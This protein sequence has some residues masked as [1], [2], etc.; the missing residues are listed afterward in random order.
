LKNSKCLLS[1][2]E[3][4][5]LDD[6]IVMSFNALCLD[7]KFAFYL[8]NESDFIEIVMSEITTCIDNLPATL[9]LQGNFNIVK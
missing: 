5:F 6:V 9:N 2:I 1:E 3:K 8:I 7:A 4:N